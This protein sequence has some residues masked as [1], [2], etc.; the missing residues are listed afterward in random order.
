MPLPVLKL[1]SAALIIV[2]G[3]A[4]RTGA[5]HEV[6]SAMLSGVSSEAK[7]KTAECLKIISVQKQSMGTFVQEVPTIHWAGC[8]LV[9][10][11]LY[12]LS[13]WLCMKT[14][15]IKLK[16]RPSHNLSVFKMYSYLTQ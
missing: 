5:C 7:Y 11:N 12:R 8:C 9:R 10:M 16:S 1:R 14:L 15:V 6:I 3:R 4:P 13:F 2:R